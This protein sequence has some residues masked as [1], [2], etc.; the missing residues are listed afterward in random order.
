MTGMQGDLTVGFTIW[1]SENNS[2][3]HFKKVK[4]TTL[5]ACSGLNK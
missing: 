3:S 2:S 4:S 1:K 5:N